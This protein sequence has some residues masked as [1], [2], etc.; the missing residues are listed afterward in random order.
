M[1]KIT[2]CLWYD[3]EAKEA[4]E[5]YVSV[6]KNS[7]MGTITYYTKSSEKVSGKPAGSVLTVS[8]QIEDQEFMALNGGSNFKFSEAVSF[9][10]DC[11]TQEEIDELWSKLTAN[12]GKA[13]PCGWLKDKF[14]LSWQITPNIL[15][16]MITDPDPKKADAA[17]AA[18]LKM[19]KI[20]IAAIQAA[21]DKA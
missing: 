4:A 18:M 7:R 8:F 20:D 13:G 9:V 21:Y 15:N 10:V 16:E 11:D 19:E 6:F 1:K 14:G 17:M 12:G 5:L 3:N 2:P